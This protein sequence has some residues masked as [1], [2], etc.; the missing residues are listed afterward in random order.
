[1]CLC[2]FEQHSNP[3]SSLNITE[4]E[5]VDIKYDCKCVHMVTKHD[6]FDEFK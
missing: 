6:I 1:M 3:K 4:T 2:E 5:N